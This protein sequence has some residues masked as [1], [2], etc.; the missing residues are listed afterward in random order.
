M[1][2]PCLLENSL[3]LYFNLLHSTRQLRFYVNLLTL[4][5][6][7]WCVFQKW[8]PAPITS[9]SAFLIHN[10]IKRVWHPAALLTADLVIG[11]SNHQVLSGEGWMCSFTPSAP[12]G[13]H[14]APPPPSPPNTPLTSNNYTPVL[15]FWVFSTFFL[16]IYIFWSNICRLYMLSLKT[17]LLTPG[18]FNWHVN[19]IR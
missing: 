6:S 9:G 19:G 3:N 10:I 13:L 18:P 15:L 1:T 17:R 8:K 16:C 5:G 7:E 14:S 12:P 4:L 2:G 11:K